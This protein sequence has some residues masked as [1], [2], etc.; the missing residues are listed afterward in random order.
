[1]GALEYRPAMG[2]DV[3]D[4]ETVHINELAKLAHEVLNSRQALRSSFSE[5]TSE[6]AIRDILR[7]GTSAGGARPKALIAW[8]PAT[9]E[10][11]SGQI[12]AG[13][14]FESW[15]LKFD[16]VAYGNS[17]EVGTTTE[18]GAVE[19]GYYL[20]ALDAGI[21][22]GESRLFQEGDQKHFMTRR[23][24]RDQDGERLHMQSLG[25][26]AHFDFNA[27]G[28]YSYE[29]VLLVIRQLR[30]GMET[31]ERMFRRMVFNAITRNQDDHVKNIAFLM[32]RT[33]T[34]SLSPA[35][36]VVWSFNPE[37]RWT[38]QHQMTING[39]RD[40]FEFVD[41]KDVAQGASMKRGRAQTILEE[42][43]GAAGRWP[44]HA[45]AAGV[46]DQHM[47]HIES[48]FRAF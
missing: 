23:F 42:V 39:K 2:P 31:T 10:V 19:Y 43:L 40:G 13:D 25:A 18:H 28:A 35:F 27:D 20:M 8:N 36:D 38:S 48:T 7:V 47:A 21:D 11:R 15:L 14:G 3:G 44:E 45:A 30:L 29:Q 9:N 46:T 26:L 41:F 22:M 12:K 24:D 17:F 5:D 33:G 34:W 32:D 4:G 1:M 37:G 6:R 16:G